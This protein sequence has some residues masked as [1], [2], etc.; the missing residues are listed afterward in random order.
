MSA[1]RLGDL[2]M[3]SN[4]ISER[5]LNAALLEQ[6]RWG[7][8]LGELLVRMSFITEDTLLKALGKQ[9]NT[10]PVNLEQIQGV[11]P[12]VRAKIPE[13][14]AKQLLAVPLQLRDQ[15]KTL[16][17]AMADPLNLNQQDSLRAISGCRV[18]VQLAGRQAIERAI[19]R[20]YR[21]V[22]EK[23]EPPEQFQLLDAQGQSVQRAQPGAP[24][25]APPLAVSPAVSATVTPARPAPSVPPAV[26]RRSPAV[27]PSAHELLH[28]LEDTQKRE[29]AVLK[30]LVELLI[31]KGI[32]TRDEYLAKL[33]AF[34]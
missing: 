32:F 24:P 28:A 10:V 27:A 33:K 31:A 2:L 14:M 3:K 9:L 30:G 12:A 25:P 34:K 19:E 15:G 7:G 13:E 20:F 22:E 16:V 4:L 18:A 6:Q 17:V 8:K 26:E 11:A 29:V 21:S 23:V 5:Q 1:I